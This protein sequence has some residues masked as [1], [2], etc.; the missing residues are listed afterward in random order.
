VRGVDGNLIIAEGTRIENAVTGSGDDTIVANDLDN[1][2]SGGSG[3]DRFV[4]HES[5][6]LSANTDTITDF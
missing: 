4:F 5:A 2:L 6:S 3:K 1:L